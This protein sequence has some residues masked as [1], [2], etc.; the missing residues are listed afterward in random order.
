MCWH[1]R[2]SVIPTH[3]L[4][5]LW[6]AL[7]PDRTLLMPVRSPLLPHPPA[8]PSSPG[9]FWRHRKGFEGVRASTH[10]RRLRLTLCL[11]VPCTMCTT[12]H[13]PAG[14]LGPLTLA[15]YPSHN[16][17][18]RGVERE[19]WKSLGGWVGGWVGGWE[20]EGGGAGG[21]GGR[22]VK[23]SC[24]DCAVSHPFL[25]FVS[26]SLC[27]PTCRSPC[28]WSFNGLPGVPAVSWHLLPLPGHHPAVLVRRGHGVVGPRLLRPRPP[29]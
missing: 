3:T 29:H 7:H 5:Q 13:K 27:V 6:S 17:V 1:A 12:L 9:S 15:S 18:G 25:P 14:R 16:W 10:H 21:M 4:L 2:L 28:C 22:H 23:V 8:H 11:H 26:R 20:R 24:G 19:F